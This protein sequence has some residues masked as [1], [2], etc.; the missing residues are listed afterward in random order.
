M[1][2]HHLVATRDSVM[3]FQKAYRDSGTFDGSMP[4]TNPKDKWPDAGDV[5]AIKVIGQNVTLVAF[6][7]T[8]SPGEKNPDSDTPRLNFTAGTRLKPFGH[9][10][11][12]V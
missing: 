11:S 12:K 6:I 4:I 3:N 7:R 1:K 10:Q 8:V 2:R 9:A 5:I